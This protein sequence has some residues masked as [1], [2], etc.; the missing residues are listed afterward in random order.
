MFNRIKSGLYILL[1]VGSMGAFLLHS[2]PVLAAAICTANVT[3]DEIRPALSDTFTVALKNTGSNGIQWIQLTVP[4][5]FSYISTTVDGWSISDQANGSILTGNTLNQNET[6][7]IEMFVSAPGT[8][9]GPLNWSIQASDDSGGGGPTTCTGS[10]TVLVMDSLANDSEFGVSNVQ[11]TQITASSATVSWQSDNPSGAIVYYGTTANY[12]SKTNYNS[13]PSTNHSVTLSGLTANTAYHALAGGIDDQGN[14]IHSADII[15]TT[16]ATASGGGSNNNSV[17]ST[18]TVAIKANPTETI[19]PII[20]LT[21]V[22]QSAFKSTPTI[23]GTAEDNE[24]LA[25]ID[26]SLDGGRNWLQADSVTGLGSKKASFS[27]TP[28]NLKDG[29]Y[30]LLARAIDTSG[31]I[32]ATPVKTLIIDRL[33]PI[34]GGNVVSQGTQA[35]LPDQNGQLLTQIN[36]DQKITLSAV[37]GPTGVTLVTTAPDSDTVLQS[38]SLSQ[39]ADTGL[40]SGIISF[41][42]AG[43]YQLTARAIDGAGNTT[44]RLIGTVRVQATGQV[45]DGSGAAVASKATVYF[46]DPET[47]T[48]ELWDGEAYDQTNPLSVSEK[49]GL[50]FYLPVGTYYLKVSAPGY[51]SIISP[52]FTMHSAGFINPSFTFARAYGASIGSRRI[53]LPWLDFSSKTIATPGAAKVTAAMLSDHSLSQFALPLTSGTQLK[54]TDLYGK[55]TILTFINTWS[56]QSRDQLGILNDLHYPSIAVIPVGSGESTARLQAYAKLA[57]Y[58]LPIAVDSDNKLANELN[59]G[60]VPVTFFLDRHGVVKT[61]KFGV[62]SKQEL[63]N[64]VSL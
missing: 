42:S 26:Y 46:R 8:N 56:D 12:G 39:S 11:V 23:S 30:L 55:P 63:L 19:P 5:Q 29:N 9:A 51:R 62:L 24:A 64:N 49:S 14:A 52:S 32:A 60:T 34:V 20:S 6:V 1:A 50:S 47:N 21:T 25:N 16:A 33:P 40:W 4:D 48:W 35:V 22:I 3:P 10:Q 28:L 53:S 45:R 31:N 54:T 44:S 37:G 36:A 18:T 57:G 61:V 41:S 58:Q 17:P 43:V 38:F 2:A 13:S 7:T 27:F 15:F 59:L